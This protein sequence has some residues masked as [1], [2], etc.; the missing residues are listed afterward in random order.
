MNGVP[1]R[2]TIIPNS[3]SISLAVSLALFLTVV[4]EMP[5]AY[6]QVLVA[7][8]NSHNLVYFDLQSGDSFIYAELPEG[9]SPKTVAIGPDGNLY[10]PLRYHTQNIV[11]LIPKTEGEGFDLV[12]FTSAIGRFGPASMVFDSDGHLLVAAG[13]ERRVFR[14]NVSNGQL[15]ESFTRPESGNVNG[16]AISGETLYVGEIFAGIIH[17]F[18]LSAAASEATVVVNDP[19]RF[20][21]P[22]GICVGHNGNLFVSN[23]E[24]PYIL[25][26]EP[27]PP[28]GLFVGNF[29]DLR[30]LGLDNSTNI[31]YSKQ[32]NRYY[33]PSDNSLYEFDTDGN[34][35]RT[36]T[37]SFLDGGRGIAFV[38][39]VDFPP[40]IH[41]FTAN[42]MTIIE[43]QSTVLQWETDHAEQLS[44]D[45]GVGDVSGTTAIEVQPDE[46]TTYTLKA[47]NGLESRESSVT[48]E[49]IRPPRIA[50]FTVSDDILVPGDSVTLTWHT[51]GADQVRLEP[52]I[53]EVIASGNVEVQPDSN[54]IYRLQASNAAGTIV[55]SIE[56][57]L[58]SPTLDSI[59]LTDRDSVRFTVARGESLDIEHSSDLIH[60]EIFA[61]DVSHSLEVFKSGLN[62]SGYFRGVRRTNSISA[63]EDL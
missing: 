23:T 15:I 7:G 40:F 41:S 4:I 13:T 42:P 33:V 22:E 61:R 44:I 35:L 38:D 30:T 49:M 47:S 37:S 2:A 25:E 57:T 26:Y 60:W 20:A 59:R 28:N 36:L 43:G 8:W 19:E 53:G 12:D 54:T 10:V 5:S 51:V 39:E 6:G 52:T 55:S 56:V 50:S 11:K 1:N 16:L 24:G 27:S 3:S 9:S 29:I 31:Q 48:V 62:S 21:R 46:T 18:N 17:S 63:E 58:V 14:Y 34:H 45:P 32:S